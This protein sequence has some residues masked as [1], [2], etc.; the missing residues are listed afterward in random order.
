M[1]VR[2]ALCVCAAVCACFV[3]AFSLRCKRP[4][5]AFFMSGLTGVAVLTVINLLSPLS[6]VWLGVNPWSVG[7]SAV[8]GV[9]GV[10][11]MLTMRVLWN[12]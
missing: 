5:R 4:L 11:L 12:I 10:L 3:I 2:I 7:C 1:I 8:A 9:P 6:G